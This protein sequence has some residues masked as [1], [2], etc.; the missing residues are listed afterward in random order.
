MQEKA[1]AETDVKEILSKFEAANRLFIDKLEAM[2]NQ[3]ASFY[4]GMKRSL[5]REKPELIS[6]SNTSFKLIKEYTY[7]LYLKLERTT[8]LIS[9]FLQVANKLMLANSKRLVVS[10]LIA[11]ANHFHGRKII[12][13][14]KDDALVTCQLI[15]E[16]IQFSDKTEQLN[17]LS[18]PIKEDSV[19]A[20]TLGTLKVYSGK[21]DEQQ[22]TSYLGG[23]SASQVVLVPLSVDPKT[24]FLL[25]CDD[26]GMD[27]GDLDLSLFETLANLAL[28][29]MEKT[30]LEQKV[31]SLEK[32]GIDFEKGEIDSLKIAKTVDDRS[33]QL[34]Q[35]EL[36]KMILDAGDLPAMPHIAGLVMN[37]LSDKNAS[38]RQIQRIISADQAL[39]AKILKVANSAFYGCTRKVSTLTDA[40]VILGF[41]TIRSLVLAISTRSILQRGS[42]GLGL[43]KEALWKHSIGCAVGCRILSGMVFFPRQEESFVCG[44]LHDIGKLVLSQNF[45]QKYKKVEE[46]V[47]K[48]K[49]SY[50]E[51]ENEI[52]GFDHTQVG[53]LLVKKWNFSQDL[54]KVIEFHHEPSRAKGIV[55]LA[56][57]TNFSDKLCNKLGIGSKKDESIVLE[58]IESA[59][60][61]NLQSPRISELENKLLE[62]LAEEELF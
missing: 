53:A 35:N 28:R 32:K 27:K 31:I 49:V 54:E 48:D 4:Q 12:F 52:L 39:A 3:F 10:E 58:E 55:E 60:I 2:E 24:T 17:R 13:A 36:E 37:R 62:A 19:F 20:T 41:N 34:V 29:M 38:A 59:I 33:K 40:V 6:K 44:L 51:A 1:T 46:K 42:D 57:I 8:C 61:L 22:I 5:D 30:D 25:Y 7:T 50:R 9:Q 23:K 14:R 21:L 18:I 16:K 15:E 26:I 43:S 45:S 56:A 11:F 47:V